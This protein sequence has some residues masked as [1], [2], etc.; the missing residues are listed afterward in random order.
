MLQFRQIES[1]PCPSHLLPVLLQPSD[2]VDRGDTEPVRWRS[3][4]EGVDLPS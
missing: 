4:E 1:F 2:D 3:G